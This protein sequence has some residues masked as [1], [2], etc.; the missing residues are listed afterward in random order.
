MD[1]ADA[2]AQEAAA[3]HVAAP[4]LQGILQQA[5]EHLDAAEDELLTEATLTSNSD[6]L[7][8]AL[9]EQH[10]GVRRIE[11]NI[12][13]LKRQKDVPS[14]IDKH[15]GSLFDATLTAL[16]ALD[17]YRAGPTFESREPLFR[18]IAR[19]QDVIESTL[20]AC[21]RGSK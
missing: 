4:D 16:H 2:A 7:R 19:L 17:V 20:R 9:V 10:R 12:V 14:Q 8:V 3:R 11:R 21:Y 1:P 18:A 13:A 15:L 6:R 5:L